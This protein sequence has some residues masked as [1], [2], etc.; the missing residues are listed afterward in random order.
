MPNYSNA[1]REHQQMYL[2]TKFNCHVYWIHLKKHDWD[3]GYIGV[4]IDPVRRLVE[5]TKGLKGRN[6]II[7]EQIQKH[8]DKIICDIIYTGTEE[9]CYELERELRPTTYIG[10]NKARGGRNNLSTTLKGIKKSKTVWNKGLKSDIKSTALYWK[11][12]NKQLNTEE[13][14]FSL[15]QWCLDNGFSYQSIHSNFANKKPYRGFQIQSI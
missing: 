7:T 9:S 15:R 13:T 3:Q 4:S 11:I 1:K 10:W 5:H 2:H 14:V 12:I 6:K 8:G